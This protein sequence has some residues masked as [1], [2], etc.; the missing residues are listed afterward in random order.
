MQQGTDLV[1]KAWVLCRASSKPSQHPPRTAK[2]QPRTLG[3]YLA[4]TCWPLPAS[5]PPLHRPPEEQPYLTQGSSLVLPAIFRL[6]RTLREPVFH[7]GYVT[8]VH[9]T[10]EPPV[11]QTARAWPSCVRTRACSSLPSGRD[12]KRYKSYIAMLGSAD[13]Q[14]RLPE[15]DQSQ[16]WRWVVVSER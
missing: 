2:Q 10:E 15:A 1:S 8:D 4:A 9:T 12:A 6:S 11:L 5:Q 14:R 3:C 13:F 7:Q 16:E